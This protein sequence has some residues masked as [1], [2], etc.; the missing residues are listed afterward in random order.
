[1]KQEIR[2][3]HEIREIIES[4]RLTDE[5]KTQRIDFLITKYFYPHRISEEEN[6]A[7]QISY[8]EELIP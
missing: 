3:L 5:Q 6:E 4:A 1:M 8:A 7:I 2:I